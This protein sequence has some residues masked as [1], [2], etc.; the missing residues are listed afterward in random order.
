MPP[1]IL[2]PD[3]KERVDRLAYN[4]AAQPK[5]RVTACNLCG[6]EHLIAI[7]HT[8]RYG[9]AATATACS[10]CGL[11]F[12][13][14]VMTREAYGDF[15]S[16]VYRPLV[17]AYHNRLIDA[18]TIQDEQREYAE[19]LGG[20]LQPWIEGASIQTSLDIGGSTGVVAVGLARKFQLKVAV[21]DPAAAELACASDFGLEAIPGFLEDY[22]PAGRQF[23]LVTLCQTI[24]HLTDA[25]GS[26]AKIRQVVAPGGFFF[27]DIVDFR[28]AYLRNQSIE[29]AIKI[30]HPYYFTEDTTTA[31]LRRAGFRILATNFAADHLH[32]G[33]LCQ[34]AA[35]EPNALPE[36]AQTREFFREIRHIQNAKA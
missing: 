22:Q 24:D 9:Y 15:Y 11:T 10:R 29:G 21:L 17:S 8:D 20:F 6:T 19:A 7:S 34:P 35:P 25:S 5:Q 14:P 33:Y 23:D 31:L 2:P 32:V 13:N 18:R 30:D 1:A 12:L 27:V 4:Y 36:A 16:G 28:A 26:L 3:R